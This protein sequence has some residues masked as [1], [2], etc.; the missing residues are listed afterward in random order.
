MSI[1]IQ[2]QQL[3]DKVRNYQ[4]NGIVGMRPTSLWV[5]TGEIHVFRNTLDHFGIMVPITTEQ[6]AKFRPDTRSATLRLT[7][8]NVEG[9]HYIR[10]ALTD[11]RQVKIF[12][13]FIDE[14]LA[15]LDADPSTPEKTVPGMLN[16][17]REL[18]R[19]SRGPIAWTREQD[20]GLLCELEVLRALHEQEI[21]DL[22]DRWTGPESFPHD[23]ELESESIECKS[24]SSLNGLRVKINGIPQLNPTLDKELRLVV[25]RYSE[26]PDGTLSVPNMVDKLRD[27]DDLDVG[28]FIAKLQK[29]GCPVFESEAETYFGRYD[30]VEVF[31]FQVTDDFPR[32]TNIG[33]AERVQQVSYTLDLSGP[34]AVSGYLTDNLVLQDVDY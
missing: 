1:K 18:F 22:M 25:R 7:S 12:T 21:P 10:L 11:P 34:S 3:F 2:A 8:Q 24:T 33:P 13:V 23:F 6:Q 17:W 15:A 9:V 26:N 30:A 31:E 32:I 27:L 5:D 28:A 4:L 14:V 29:L 16:R 20:L 19:E